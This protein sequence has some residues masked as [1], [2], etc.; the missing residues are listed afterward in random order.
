ML[1]YNKPR[2]C[3]L[4]KATPGLFC[5]SFYECASSMPSLRSSLRLITRYQTKCTAAVITH[6]TG[7]ER[8]SM[9]NVW[10]AANIV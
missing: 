7:Y 2:S 1:V 4:G 8:Y 9:N 5:F 6:E 10:S 3:S